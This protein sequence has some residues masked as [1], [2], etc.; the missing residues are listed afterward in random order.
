VH[1]GEVLGVLCVE[2]LKTDAG[3][4]ADQLLVAVTD[5]QARISK[6]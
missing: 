1:V 4:V 2:G 3:A 6:L 5:L